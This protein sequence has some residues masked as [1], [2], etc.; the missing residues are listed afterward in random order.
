MDVATPFNLSAQREAE[1][2]SLPIPEPVVQVISDTNQENFPKTNHVS[3]S[4]DI[5]ILEDD[6][7]NHEN[8]SGLVSKN[9]EQ[10]SSEFRI[11]NDKS[12]TSI[13]VEKI[14]NYK[15]M[16]Q[17]DDTFTEKI[18]VADNTNG[19]EEEINIDDR[20]GI[21][22]SSV[23]SLS[24]QLDSKQSD[25]FIDDLLLEETSPT[26]ER[27]IKFQSD[28]NHSSSKKSKLDQ[29]CYVRIT[30]LKTKANSIEIIK[31]NL[32]QD[33]LPLGLK[34]F[35]L[36]DA[37]PCVDFPEST[38]QKIVRPKLAN[39]SIQKEKVYGFY[40]GCWAIET[41]E[42]EAVENVS[43]IVED[44]DGKVNQSWCQMASKN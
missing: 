3:T 16:D 18:K 12:Q 6:T 19:G 2:M 4:Q 13:N 22:I 41:S 21:K 32:P 24:E 11:N 28:K 38:K 7:I 36:L 42:M 14:A 17:K 5:I 30:P 34:N 44:S 39:D 43:M 40:N 10:K 33:F 8:D 31:V 37:Q 23:I 29:G 20:F 27:K 1:M 25:N 15:I 9:E 35:D 26:K